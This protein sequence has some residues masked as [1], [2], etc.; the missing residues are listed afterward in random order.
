MSATKRVSGDYVIKTVGTGSEIKLVSEKVV[1]ESEILIKFID[2]AP[3]TL[4]EHGTIYA[5]EPGAGGTGLFYAGPSDS[6]ELISKKKAI[7]FSLIF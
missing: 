7:L 2:G 4:F 6:G 3:A 1:T 5:A